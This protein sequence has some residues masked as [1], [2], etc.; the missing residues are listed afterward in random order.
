MT[1][2]KR[3]KRS[4]IFL[5]PGTLA[6]FDAPRSQLRTWVMSSSGEFECPDEALDTANSGLARVRLFEP[7]SWNKAAIDDAEDQ[8]LEEGRVLSIERAVDENGVREVRTG[9]VMLC[10]LSR[11]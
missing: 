9:Q 8:R 1:V 4:L 11:R 6:R 10:A 2:E 7:A 3:A 5:G